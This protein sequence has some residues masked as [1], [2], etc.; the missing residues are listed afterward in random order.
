MIAPAGKYRRRYLR[1]KC[2]QTQDETYGAS[3]LGFTDDWE[4]WGTWPEDTATSEGEDRGAAISE[5]AAT[6]R[7]RGLPELSAKDRL[8][9]VAADE[10]YLVLGV[11]RDR[12]AWE[13][14]VSC[15]RYE[16]GPADD[17]GGV[18]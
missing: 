3:Q 16:A 10:E 5:T 8:L 11:K 12:E 6:I 15:A 13:L 2:S 9:D 14:I 1:K 17:Q 7:I 18:K 4:R